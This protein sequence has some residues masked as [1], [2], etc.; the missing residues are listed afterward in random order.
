ME[1]LHL[2]TINRVRDVSFKT[3]TY[4]MDG[5][6]KRSVQSYRT[7]SH[8][9]IPIKNNE[10]VTHVTVFIRSIELK[11]FS[12]Y[13]RIR[14]YAHVANGKLDKDPMSPQVYCVYEH[15][16]S[17]T[18]VDVTYDLLSYVGGGVQ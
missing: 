8:I 16:R 13:V 11:Y 3:E 9:Q 14:V 5:T 4:L 1:H 15:T 17:A 6:E 12:A 10:K 7:G 18:G 2:N